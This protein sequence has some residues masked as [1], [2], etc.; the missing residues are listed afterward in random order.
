MTGILTGLVASVFGGK[1]RSNG[2]RYLCGAAAALIA[3][4]AIFGMEFMP[5][6]KLQGDGHFAGLPTRKVVG[7]AGENSVGD[8]SQDSTDAGTNSGDGQNDAGNGDSNTGDQTQA[9]DEDSAAGRAGDD[10]DGQADRGRG[11]PRFSSRNDPALQSQPDSAGQADPA[12]SKRFA[13]LI[14]KK[15][16]EKWW[17]TWL[18]YVLSGIGVLFAYQLARGFSPAKQD[19]G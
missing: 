4:G 8:A 2:A 9:S 19:G 16:H 7:D 1:D 6:V 3:G 14:K 15:K 12:A 17:Q 5:S 13:E 10:P 18:P 11:G